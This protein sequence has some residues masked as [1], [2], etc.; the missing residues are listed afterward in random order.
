MHM[1]MHLVLTICHIG[2]LHTVCMVSVETPAKRCKS[3]FNINLRLYSS[4]GS[5]VCV[6]GIEKVSHIT[7]Y[8]YGCHLSIYCFVWGKRFYKTI[9]KQLTADVASKQTDTNLSSNI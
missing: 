5:N 1:H 8:G 3:E 2:Y 6:C 7:I 4:D 9:K